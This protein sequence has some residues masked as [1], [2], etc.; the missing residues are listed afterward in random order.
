[1]SKGNNR[2]ITIVTAFVLCLVLIIVGMGLASYTAAEVTYNSY[3]GYDVPSGVNTGHPYD[4]VGPVISIF[5][6]AALI[7]ASIVTIKDHNKK[8][9]P[10][11]ALRQSQDDSFDG[12]IKL[13]AL[14]DSGAITKAEFEEQKKVTLQKT[15][16]E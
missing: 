5:G 16:G 15:M 10:V 4:V 3:Y 8:A 1:M 6:V 12:L 11:S 14:L 9:R 13:K 7:P 2:K